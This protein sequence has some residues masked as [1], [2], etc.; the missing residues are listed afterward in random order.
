MN[1]GRDRRKTK[2][3]NEDDMD[4]TLQNLRYHIGR[5][6]NRVMKIE[7]SVY[8]FIIVLVLIQFLPVLTN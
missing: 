5:V 4:A 6:E 1:R 7:K 2:R 8:F 3:V